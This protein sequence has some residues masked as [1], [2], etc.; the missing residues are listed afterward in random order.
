MTCVLTLGPPSA[1]LTH[2]DGV[3]GRHE[4]GARLG[5]RGDANGAAHVVGEDGEGGAVGDD[6]CAY[7]EP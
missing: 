2:G 1:R 7:A 3:V 6:A 5:Q 4:D